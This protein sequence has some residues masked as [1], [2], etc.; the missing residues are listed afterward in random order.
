MR[1]DQTAGRKVFVV[2]GIAVLRQYGFYQGVELLRGGAKGQTGD[3][4]QE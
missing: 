1:D 2:T 3:G 4:E